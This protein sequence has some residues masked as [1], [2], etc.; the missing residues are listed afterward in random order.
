MKILISLNLEDRPMKPLSSPYGQ[1]CNCYY[2]YENISPEQQCPAC[3]SLK[4]YHNPWPED[5]LIELW[6]E[7]VDIWNWGKV[8]LSIIVAAMYFE[9]SVFHL[10]YLGTA[11][12]HPKLNR[13]DTSFEET[14]KKEEDIW[15]NLNKIRTRK[16]T[17][18]A[19]QRVFGHSSKEMLRTVLGNAEAD[20][21]WKQYQ[22]LAKDRNQIIHRG[23]RH[24]VT[25][26]EGRV[27]WKDSKAIEKL[28][29]CLKW[30]PICWVVFSRLHNEYI[31]PPMWE[32]KKK[33][34]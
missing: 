7:Q 9:S 10:L 5:A 20:D 13:L 28:D 4:Q 3:S 23:R 1:C 25:D 14:P 11:W 32:K 21:Y 12:L 29:W 19:L 30:I 17:D 6:K 8:E 18:V 2:I 16:A 27:I 24:T 33:G 22:E 31:H 34:G 15:K 26:E